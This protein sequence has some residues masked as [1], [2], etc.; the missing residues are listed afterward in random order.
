MPTDFQ[1]KVKRV[2]KLTNNAGSGEEI[3][4]DE[5]NKNI[6]ATATLDKLFLLSYSEIVPATHGEGEIIPSLPGTPIGGPTH[7][8]AYKYPWTS[9]EHPVRG[10]PRQGDEEVFEQRLSAA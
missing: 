9:S 6:S 10:L 7:N 3:L 1:V 5:E 8:W 4:G 2:K